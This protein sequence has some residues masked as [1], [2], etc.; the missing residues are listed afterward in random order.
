[1]SV[2]D[3]PFYDHH[4]EVVFHEQTDVGLR[5][6]IAIHNTQLGPAVGGCRMYSYRDS[7]SAMDDVLQLSRGMTYK[8]ALAGLPMGGGKAVI[9]GDPRRDKSPAL[10]EA[11]AAVVDSLGGRYVTAEDSG[12][13][14]ADMAAMRRRSPYVMGAQA[15]ND[16]GADPSPYT[17]RGVFLGIG[18]A[19]AWRGEGGL[20]GK[21]VA[22]QGAG[23]VGSALSRLLLEA[24]ATVFISDPDERRCAALQSLGAT[25]VASDQLITLPVDVL[26]PCALGA[27]INEQ[28]VEDIQA[29]VIAGAANNTLANPELAAVL[30][31][32]GVLYAPD[33]AINAG[34]IIT[35]H[36]QRSGSTLAA[37][38]R[39]IDGIADTLS[40]VFAA[41][42][43]CGSTH[44]AAEQLAMAA[45]H[46]RAK[47]L[48]AAG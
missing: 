31:G 12:T 16:I 46:Q 7:A 40:A 9:L 13:S 27:V 25:P 33:F 8:S 47:P 38:N 32:R 24:G 29:T 19:L 39:H 45:L 22:V 48:R 10:L 42:E 28:N 6:I 44:V 21:T 18:A 41:G 37:L 15:C 36:H 2:F 17:A 20:E 4:E 1:M 34:G 26:A 43:R 23:A 35:V 3:S 11:M 5:C 14:V 30:A